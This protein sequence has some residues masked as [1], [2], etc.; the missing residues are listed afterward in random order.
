[1][2]LADFDYYLPKN[3][4]A[5][6]PLIALHGRNQFP[7]DASRLL[8]LDKKSGK[9]LHSRFSKITDFIKA[10]DVLVLND[11]KVFPAR[12]FGKKLTGGKIE[13]L[14]LKDKGKGVWESLVKGSN[15]KPGLKIFFPN[16]EGEIIEKR[17]DGMFKIMFNKEGKP[18][19]NIID[20]IGYTPLPP[21][22]KTKQRKVKEYQTCYA[23]YLGSAAAP[24]AGFHF[25]PELLDKLKKQGIQIE[26]ITLHI[27]LGTF[28]PVREKNIEDHK[29][30]K[31]F[32]R[33]F[34]DVARRLNIAKA[35]KRRIVACGTTVCRAL[36]AFSEKVEK[37]YQI[38]SGEKEIDN[39]IYPRYKFKFVDVL[40]T[41]FHLPKT[42]LLMLVSAFAGREKILKAYHEAI[43]NKYR[44][45]SFGD[46][47]LIY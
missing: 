35:E 27:G 45:Y 32:A 9:I 40:I 47:M 44:F 14:L 11:T 3:L 22:I 36:E 7:R 24:T 20:K 37:F 8:I 16:L 29:M 19:W 39:I 17:N 4:I 1:M 10:G 13:I 2:K 34:C 31:E 33:I 15:I 38:K 26:Y 23:K 42:T 30:H 5:Q 25:T 21:Y 43:K 18:F 12:L 28:L 46:A 41:N 6:E